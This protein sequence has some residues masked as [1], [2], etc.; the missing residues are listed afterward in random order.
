MAFTTTLAT[1]LQ[2]VQNKLID[3]EL[4]ADNS[5][6]LSLAPDASLYPPS[7]HFCAIAPGRQVADAP[8]VVGVGFAFVGQITVAIWNRLALDQV[9]RA[10]SYLTDASLGLLNK[11]Q[12]VLTSLQMFMPQDSNGLLLTEPMRLLDI[13]VPRKTG[14]PDWGVVVSN[15]EVKY[16]NDLSS[17]PTET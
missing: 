9:P 14:L 11:L 12:D 4:F 15:W 6:F 5:C 7:D 17:P 8:L 10:D 3:D 13:D 2:T 16:L 1:V